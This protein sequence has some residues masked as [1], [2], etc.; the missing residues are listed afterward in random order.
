[1]AKNINNDI[2]KEETKL[3]LDI[4]RECFKEWFPVFVYNPFIK[5]IYIYDLFAG[6]GTD[7]G[8][9]FGSPL[10]LL[11][12]AKGE[13]N[14]YCKYFKENGKEVAFTFNELLQTK[15]ELLKENVS[16]YLNNCFKSC[17]LDKCIYEEKCHFPNLDFQEIFSRPKL[18]KILKKKD[19]GKFILLDQ[20]GFN[21]VN[22]DVF[23]KL[24]DSPKTDFIFFIASSFIKRFKELPAVTAYFAKGKI[25]FDETKPAECHRIIAGYFRSLIPEDKEYYLHHF[26]IKK[27]ANYYGL[28]F[29]SNHTFGMEKFLSVCWKKDDLAGESSHNVNND[30][31]QGTFFYNP[32]ETNKIQEVREELRILIDSGTIKTNIDG[33]KFALKRGCQPKIFVDL[34][35]QLVKEKYVTIDGKFNKKASNIHAISSKDIYLIKKM[36]K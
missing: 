22:D 30:Y 17:E 34:M 18:Q 27:G 13:G 35:T 32:Q 2:F 7:I 21:K 23:L 20:Y 36:Q 8:G 28:I 5:K 6:S 3:K 4:F 31:E 26:S 29:G 11:D 1:M 25:I 19:Y 16:N 9:T 15:N 33:L 10:I 14:R 24:V 12:E